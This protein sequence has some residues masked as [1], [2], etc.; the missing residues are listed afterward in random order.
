[1][2]DPRGF[3]ADLSEDDEQDPFFLEEPDFAGVLARLRAGEALRP[4]QLRHLGYARPTDLPEWMAFWTSLSAERRLAL[5][6]QLVEQSEADLHAD[7]KLLL[8]PLLDDADPAIRALAIDGL[9]EREDAAF[10]RR[11][12]KILRHD[13]DEEVRAQAAASLG[14]FILRAEEDDAWSA[15]LRASHE[16]LL[17]VAADEAASA[18]LRRQALVA[19]GHAVRSSLLG[20][21]GTF[22]GSEDRLL[23]AGGLRAAGHAMD[24]GFARELLEAL[25]DPDPLLRH[26]AALAAGDMSL[27]HAVAPLANLAEF[28]LDREVRL[29]AIG[30]LG[31]IGSRPAVKALERMQTRM[32]LDDDDLS[33]AVEDALAVAELMGDLTALEAEGLSLGYGEDDGQED[34]LLDDEDDGDP[35]LDDDDP[36]LR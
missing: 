13:S 3:F 9:W 1:M 31:N 33:D 30:A 10:A 34:R 17:D 14:S 2:I 6:T 4:G 28:D 12:D 23:R 35:V 15:E 32:D 8:E 25:D 21:I 18:E 11:L 24:K 26:E 22:I 36:D 19:A 5:L 20:L 16:L 29:A 27:G 7:Y